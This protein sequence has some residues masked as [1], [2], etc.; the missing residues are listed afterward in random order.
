MKTCSRKAIIRSSGMFDIA[1]MLP[2]AIPGVAAWVLSQLQYIHESLAFSGSFP[3]FSGLHLLFVSLMAIITIVWSFLRY[4][5]PL[6][7]YGV[8]DSIARF[9]IITLMLIYTVYFDVS[10]VIL[11]FLCV[12]LAW[13]LLQLNALQFKRERHNLLAG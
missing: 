3:E 2:F 7:I 10:G 9:G 11:V 4:R 5:E 8:Y 6:V 12:E 1:L 13:L